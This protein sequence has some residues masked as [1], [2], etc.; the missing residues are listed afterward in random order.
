MAAARGRRAVDPAQLVAGLIAIAASVAVAVATAWPIYGDARLILAAAAGTL[1][2]SGGVLAGWALRWRWWQTALMITIAYLLVVVPVAIPSAMTSPARLLAG[3]GTGLTDIVFGWK[4]LLTIS[5]PAA[6]YQSVLVPFLFTVTVSTL[7][8]TALIVRGGRWAPFAAAPM[9]AMPVFGAYFGTSQ[10]RPDLR[11][12]PFTIPAPAHVVLGVAAVA[13]CA[14]WL[15]VRSRIARAE[16]IRT[17][18]SRTGT[19]RLGAAAGSAALRRHLLTAGIVVVALSVAAAAAPVSAAIGDREVPRDQIDPLLMLQRQASPLSSYRQWFRTDS[20]DVPLFTVTGATGVDRVRIATL[21][22]YDG[23]VY[24]VDGDAELSDFSRQPRTQ[25]ADVTITIGVGYA[26]VWVPLVTADGGAPQFGGERASALADSYYAS[27]QL[28]AG[29]IVEGQDRQSVEGLRAG[30]VYSLAAAAAPDI[31]A[32]RAAPGGDP[33]ISEEQHPALTAWADAQELDRSGASLIELV[34]RLRAR[35]YISHSATEDADA[36]SWM[37]DLSARASFAFHGSRSGHSTAR[38]E[39][40][41]EALLDQQERA[42]DGASE[43]TLVAAVGDDEQFATAAALLAQHLGF[44]AR[45]VVGVRLADAG[46]GWAV[47]P[48]AEVC[49]GANVTAWAEAR[50]LDGEWVALDATPQFTVPPSLIEEGQNPPENPTEPEQIAAEVIDP[51]TILSETVSESTPESAVEDPTWLQSNLRVILAIASVAV[52]TLLLILPLLVFP[53][54]KRA[55][56]RWR[57]RAH[58]PEVAMVGAWEELID[59]YVDAGMAVPTGL[60]RAETAD[61][62]DRPAAASI[63]ATVDRAVFAEHPP[64]IDTSTDLWAILDDER[65]A[66]RSELPLRRRIRASLTPASFLRRIRAQHADE[67]STLRRKDSHGPE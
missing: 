44:E 9:L 33:L 11:L 21:N 29:V 19:A 42:G 56:R 64:A 24:H 32:F 34:D 23:S 46:S 17:A 4:R 31:D 54:A 2:G 66:V 25:H 30:D 37:A 27:P 12:G 49:T 28:D 35:G 47:E 22:S 5:V 63:A 18:R 1:V 51:P 36:S 65:R 45:V 16:A 43:E 3:I 7:I 26:G 62:L 67:R 38:V 20:F 41:F 10:T 60:T 40:L 48:C 50:S 61:I 6:D 57:R 59:R 52:G 53:I 58:D 13:V 55:H 39:D 14:C 15:L 8:A